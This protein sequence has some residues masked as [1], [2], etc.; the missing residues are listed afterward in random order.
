MVHT[1]NE[2][3][4]DHPVSPKKL[5]ANRKNA[6]RST[7]PRTAKGKQRSSQN[8]FQH[9][10][11]S[12][13]LFSTR[14]LIARDW[15]GYKQILAAYRGQYSPVGNLE[16]YYIEQIAGYS[17]RL[18][19][20][21]EYEQ[22]VLAYGTPF[23]FR[24][25][26]R[27]VRYE[28]NISRL[29]EK[30]INQLERLQAARQAESSQFDSSNPEADD[31]PSNTD[32]TPEEQ[33]DA[34]EELTPEVTQEV[35]TSS[36]APNASPTTAQKHVESGAKQGSVPVNGEQSNKTPETPAGSAPA[37]V[38]T[39]AKIIEKVAG[40][41]PAEEHKSSLGSHDNHETDSIGSDKWVESREDEEMIERYKRGDDIDELY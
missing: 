22:K 15:E 8:P 37:S 2:N 36:S 4:Q 34:P 3:H 11:F 27:I 12:N 6:M 33:P 40:L 20:L 17:L 7:G 23:E 35:S 16:N 39:L 13:R 31:A 30:A 14:E 21:L 18:A 24:S 38:S 29:L 32:D 9:G 25:M 1:M 5:A 10:F 19:R 26:D 41:T 28:S